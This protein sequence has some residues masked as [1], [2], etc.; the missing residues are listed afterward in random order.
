MAKVYGQSVPLK[1]LYGVNAA[2]RLHHAYLFH[3]PEGIGKFESALNFAKALFCETGGGAYCDACSSC[4]RINEYRHPDVLVVATDDRAENAKYFYD[5]YCAAPSPALYRA[6]ISSARNVLA[7]VEN[8]LLP[9][10]ENYPAF[11]PKE[12]MIGAKSDRNRAAAME[13]AYLAA[14]G[15]IARLT[16]D[17]MMTLTGIYREESA[18]AAEAAKSHGAGK[19]TFSAPDLFT[20]LTALY[21]NVSHTTIPIDTIRAVISRVER[22]SASGRRIVIIEGIERMESTCANVFLHTLEEPPPG[23]L[24]ILLSSHMD[25]IPAS[26]RGPLSSRTM[27]LEFRPLSNKSAAT[28]LEKTFG[29]PAADAAGMAERAGGSLR[30]AMRLGKSGSDGKTP[31]HAAKLLAAAK[32]NDR[33]A[34]AGMLADTKGEFPT[35][36]FLGDLMRTAADMVRSREGGLAPEKAAALEAGIGPLFLDISTE[37][38]ILFAEELDGQIKK[39]RTSNISERY[40]AVRVIVSVWLW[41]RRPDIRQ[42]VRS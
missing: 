7:R 5:R 14:S 42:G 23:N 35:T 28:I 15:T 20:A 12:H 22:K 33:A 36:E 39:A 18:L 31:G 2:D 24:F 11:L 17:R 41:L 3:G 34:V 16:P 9:P 19:K 29:F 6:F 40:L 21:Y 26:V 10:Y 27:Q 37:S 30:T 38:I 4:T 1:I 32:A 25:E 13:S 8:R